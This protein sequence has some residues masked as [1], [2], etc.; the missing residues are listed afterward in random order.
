VIGWRLAHDEPW[1]NNQVA[2]LELEGRR[3][4]FRLEKALP[5]ES[6]EGRVRIEEVFAHSIAP[7]LE[8]AVP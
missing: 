4:I 8:F 1:F 7:N 5:D 3:A 2:M 6:G